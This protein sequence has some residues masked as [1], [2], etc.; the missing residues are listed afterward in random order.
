MKI[1]YP[2]QVPDNGA[3][4][5]PHLPANRPSSPLQVPKNGAS[6]A[7]KVLPEKASSPLQVPFKSHTRHSPHT[8]RGLVSPPLGVRPVPRPSPVSVATAAARREPAG[9]AGTAHRRGASV[10]LWCAE[11]SGLNNLPGMPSVG[12]FRFL[13]VGEPAGASRQSGADKI[14]SQVLIYY[15]RGEKAVPL[16]SRRGVA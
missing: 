2:L 14:R 4:S 11:P 13:A 12:L 16:S 3:S 15:W 5:A 6:S 8:P 7:F 10:T 9:E 1:S